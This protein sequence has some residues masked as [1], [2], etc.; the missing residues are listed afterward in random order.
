M[1]E[2][3]KDPVSGNWVVVGYERTQPVDINIC[4]FCPGNE[5]MTSHVIREFRD[6]DGAWLVRC[7]PAAN[8]V[9]A[10]EVPEHK[11]AEGIFDKMGNVG[12]HEIVVEARSHTKTLS[13]FDEH[14]L[15]LLFDMYRERIMD[16]KKDKRFRYVHV[17]KNHGQLAG[18][19]IFHPHSHVLATPIVPQRVAW[20]LTNSRNHYRQ[21]ERCLF[22]DI[23]AQELRQE[24]RV[25]S[26][27]DRFAAFTPF[28][29]RFPF[30]VWIAPR[31]HSDS[32][33]SMT[34]RATQKDFISLF[35]EIMK[36][37][38]KV[39]PSYSVSIHTSPNPT[40]RGFIEED[41]PVSDYF[42]WHLEILPRD[43]RTSTYKREDEF[44]VISVT[45]EE[46]AQLLKAQEV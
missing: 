27:N 20:E 14:Q 37:V 4:P 13:A 26:V 32:F 25:V 34:D 9:F 29:P 45:P 7:F 19:A 8:P 39:A 24:K 35:L 41:V 33:E 28:A 36:R 2:L 1:A 18:S 30:E 38:E 21:K 16:L 44:Y 6:A 46:T 23:I 15:S 11:R 22:C 3:R 40:E 12:A 17:F 31:R 10:I 43:L 5:H 42:H